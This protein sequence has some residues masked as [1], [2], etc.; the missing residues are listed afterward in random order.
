M[1]FAVSKEWYGKPSSQTSCADNELDSKKTENTEV[2]HFID[3]IK[4]RP[5]LF[6]RIIIMSLCLAFSL[7]AASHE[8]KPTTASVNFKKDSSVEL[9]ITTNI[10]TLVT[11]LNPQQDAKHSHHDPRY[12]QLR[13]LSEIDL[14]QE[15]SNVEP[16][17]RESINL[18]LSGQKPEWQL[19]NI[20]I[21][22]VGNHRIPRKSTITYITKLKPE[23]TTAS[24]QYNTLYGDSIV[25]FIK[26]EGKQKETYWLTKGKTS[27]KFAFDPVKVFEKAK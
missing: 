20:H 24:W 23:M 16:S 27:P 18:L 3:I 26:N 25:H 1:D 17:Y 10:E 12:K 8:T 5:M 13:K 7:P 22:E 2:I 14:K 11:R 15:F 6:Y 19:A 21:P 4:E 9:T